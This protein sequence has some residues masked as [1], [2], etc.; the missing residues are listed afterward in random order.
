MGRVVHSLCTKKL[1][2]ENK[3]LFYLITA[4]NALVELCK[5]GALTGLEMLHAYGTGRRNGCK[6]LVVVEYEAFLI[7]MPCSPLEFA[8][9]LR[10]EEAGREQE[11]AGCSLPPSCPAMALQQ[12]CLQQPAP[13]CCSGT[14]SW[15]TSWAC[16]RVGWGK[17][18]GPKAKFGMKMR[19]QLP[20]LGSTLCKN[21]KT[22]TVSPGNLC[23]NPQSLTWK[24]HEQCQVWMRGEAGFLLPGRPGTWGW[25][26]VSLSISEAAS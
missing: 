8:H 16:I 25:S 1:K 13:W 2:W 24:E 17:K 20:Q 12:L 9:C 7:L 10:K 11:P 15:S 18:W 22:S 19:Y 6:A 5:W 4:L 14:C 21:L 23:T 26:Q 3:H